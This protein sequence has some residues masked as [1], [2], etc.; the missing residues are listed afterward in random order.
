MRKIRRKNRIKTISTLTENDMKQI[1]TLFTLVALSVSSFFGQKASAQTTYVDNGSSTSYHLNPGDSLCIKSGTYTGNIT[2]WNA[3]AK[4]SVE[5]G[6]TFRP[7]SLQNYVFKLIVR[8]NATLPNFS[9]LSGF[10]LENYGNITVNG[11]AQMAQSAQTFN[12]YFG[13][14]I[15]FNGD[16]AMN[17][18]GGHFINQGD[19]VVNGT[20]SINSAATFANR[21]SI[22][23]NGNINVNGGTLSNLGR[24]YATGKMTFASNSVFQNNC[25]AIADNGIEISNASATVY[26]NGLLWST[27]SKNNSYFTNSGTFISTANAYVK[28]ANLTNWGTIRG[29]GYFYFTGNTIGG[30]NI[31]TAGNTSDTIRVYDVTRSNPNTIFDSH[32]SNVYPNVKYQVFSAPDTLNASIGACAP[33]TATL[34]LAVK[35]NYFLVNL[36]NNVPVLEWSAQLDNST[37]FEV[38]RSYDGNNFSTIAVVLSAEEMQKYQYADQQVN[39]QVKVVYYRIRAVE[40]S[41]YVKFS[42]VRSVRFANT[43]NTTVQVTPNPFTSQFSIGYTAA[44]RENVQIRVINLSGQVMVTRSATMNAGFNSLTVTEASSLTKGM[45]LVQIVSENRVVASEKLL[46]Q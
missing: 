39:T 13:A 17:I 9:T 46:K 2:S 43:T 14:T 30:G 37:N 26:N 12:N 24:F 29:A 19:M 10:S 32:N 1:S 7:N 25:R 20:F 35:W 5:Q 42:D 8:G 21:R 33:E 45:Y 3:G 15:T 36:S 38:Q 28:A 31:G 44:A 27:V 34:P 23:V 41:G 16:F 22:V 4:I 40:P 11:Y 18:S 6:A